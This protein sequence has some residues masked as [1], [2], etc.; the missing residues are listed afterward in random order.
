MDEVCPNYKVDPDRVYLPGLS[1]GGFGTWNLG[2][3][4]PERFAA[5]APICGGGEIGYTLLAQHGFTTPQTRQELKGM[6]VWAFH[7]GKD[8]VV[9]PS[10]SERMV[11]DL[12]QP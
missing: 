5:L 1:M 12:Q 7:G 6:S 4:H 8:D 2:T 9:P 10:E 11:Q 3:A